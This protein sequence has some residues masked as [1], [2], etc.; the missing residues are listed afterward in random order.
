M[1]KYN[2]S[3]T[4][5]QVQSI[6][7]KANLTATLLSEPTGFTNNNN[8]I[9][10]YDDV[11]RTIT[12]SGDFE[13]YYKGVK[14][15]ELING[16]TSDPHPVPHGTYF[17]HYCDG[18]FKFDT[19]PW[20][21][22][23]LQIT[24]V[25]SNNYRIWLREVHGFMDWRTHK[26]FHETL[27]TY[28]VSGGNLVA[29]SYTLGSTV[30]GNRRPHVATTVIQDEDLLT[31]LAGST[32]RLYTHRYMSVDGLRAFTPL[33]SDILPVIGST[34]QWNQK[35]SEGVWQQTPMVN[36]Q[37]ACVFL[38]AIPVTSDVESQYYRYV[39]IQPQ[40]V[41]TLEQA[42]AL[43][44]QQLDIGDPNTLVTEFVYVNKVI[45]YMT[46]GNWSIHST[47]LLT[48]SRYSQIPNPQ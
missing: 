5:Q 28:R 32:D 24:Y 46:A 2:L 45:I 11:A 47:R 18:T 16:W 23:C 15:P 7:E 10:T 25:Q 6:L 13:A 19:T 9:V 42:L 29:G 21:F 34:P 48:G 40:Q 27:G 8:I 41:G 39:W 33:Q 4:G 35:I 30:A 36:G 44:P 3:F 1:S 20:Y 17:L 22:D 37:Y 14:I 38:V 31:T 26:V 43:L 12:L